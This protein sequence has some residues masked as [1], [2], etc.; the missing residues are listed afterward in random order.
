MAKDVEPFL[1]KPNDLQ[2]VLLFKE[3]I[4]SSTL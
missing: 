2:K 3:I 4:E 1:F